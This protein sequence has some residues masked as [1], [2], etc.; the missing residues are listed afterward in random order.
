MNTPRR[1]ILISALLAPVLLLSACSS[2]RPI[3]ASETM[4][5]IA[6]EQMDRAIDA[7]RSVLIENRFTIDRVDA[8][9]GVLTTY[10]KQ[11]AGIASPWDAEQSSFDQEI[12]DLIHHHERIIRVSF[13]QE[14]AGAPIRANVHASIV[15]VRRPGWRLETESIRRSTHA[16]RISSNNT[17]V[18]SIQ[19]EQIGEDDRLSARIAQQIR[20]RLKLQ[21]EQETSG[22]SAANSASAPE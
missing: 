1:I 8:R 22:H 19:R 18:P 17:D 7:A 3:E 9:R 2:S 12:A 20:D 13:E 4:I 16:R 21:S 14:H 11:S 6:P 15:R 5:E 10:P